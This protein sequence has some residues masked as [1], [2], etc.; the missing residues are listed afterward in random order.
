MSDAA[1]ERFE[2]FVTDSPTLAAA[3]YWLAQVTT[4]EKMHLKVSAKSGHDQYFVL[5]GEAG[6][7]PGNITKVVMTE[8]KGWLFDFETE[9]ESFHAGVG[10][11]WV[12]NSPRR[13]LE[14]VTRKVTDA[15]ARISEGKA[16]ELRLGNLEAKRDWGYAGDYVE[17]M[18]AMLQQDQPDDYVISTGATHTVRELC[19]HAFNRV[20]LDYKK[21]VVV[22]PEYF[23]PAEVELL[24]GDASKAHTKLGWRPKV[25]FKQLVEMMVDADVERTKRESAA[26]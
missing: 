6:M 7:A 24:I 12:H 25:T 20:G 10:D 17:A 5:F 11:A 9:S 14:F 13:G 21:Y 15:A 2:E 3:L 16:N 26:I 1:S 19:E 18:W 22:D 23:R 8:Y 4:D